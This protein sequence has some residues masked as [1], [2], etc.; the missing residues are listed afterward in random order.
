MN[1][2]L[3]IESQYFP[4]VDVYIAA[5]HFS[6]IKI[7]QYDEYHKMSFRNRSVVMGG[8]GPINLSIPLLNGRSQKGIFKD[9]RIDPR[10]NWRSQHWKTIT[11]CYNRSPWFY[12]Y[13]LDLERLFSARFTFLLDWNMACFEWVNRQ[14]KFDIA[15]SLTEKFVDHYPD[16]V[17]LRNRFFPKNIQTFPANKKYNQVFSERTG[18]IPHMSILDLLFCEGKRAKEYLVNE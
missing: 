16:T 18:F 7:E 12:F 5:N 6:H 15:V 10:T 13:I 11:S 8:N 14:L 3:I 9:V 4:P 1:S 17:D 2:T